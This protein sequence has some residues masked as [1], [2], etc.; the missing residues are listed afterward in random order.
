MIYSL[1]VF[2]CI[3]SL[4]IITNSAYA[5]DDEIVVFHTQ[6]GNL[7]IETFSDDAPNT[8][9]NFLKL[10]KSGFYD[11]TIFHRVIEDFMIQG[12][13]PLTKP[14]AYEQ[15]SQWGTGDAGYTI[16]AEFNN[17]K[18]NRGVVSMA[19]AT[20]P[21]S[22][23]SQFFIVHKNSN[24]LDGQYT[25]FG[26]IITNE[27]FETLDKIAILETANNDIPFDWGKGEILETKVVDRSELE[28]ILDLGEPERMSELTQQI[29]DQEYSNTALGISFKAPEGWSVQEPQ[30]ANPGIPDVIVVGPQTG[31]FPSTF[32][33][34]VMSSSGKTFDQHIDE[35][36]S[37]LQPSIEAG[38]LEILS[39]EKTTKNGKDSFSLSAVGNFPTD[40]GIL[41]V[42]F[43]EITFQEN[44]KFY[45]LTYTN[46]EQNFNSV[47]DKYNDFVESFA[48]NEIKQ[49]SNNDDNS[50]T[51]TGGCLIATATFGSELAPQV[52]QLRE[53]RDNTILNTQ[54]GTSFMLGFN[55]FYYSFS[56]SI[57]DL[58]REN[59]I[60]KE[61]VKITIT[62]LLTTLSILNYIDIDSEE[63]VLGYGIGI[64]LLNVGLYFV[65]PIII[66]HRLRKKYNV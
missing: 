40:T 37:L 7:V 28:N 50:P 23:S 27:S 51:E 1:S 20:D 36:I 54:I 19:R 63:E 49:I 42:K 47:L 8:S 32:S 39:Q 21:D 31:N 65:G 62:P 46:S 58:E 14:G 34:T 64:I 12:G 33:V 44:G 9:E 18:H 66:I 38:N 10:A 43:N 6:S 26:R 29:S 3:F 60:F 55:Q 59:P 57:A 25:V 5:Q 13:D 4:L 2:T 61:I 22:A 17:I 48:V 24:F 15:T 53:L 45:A 41:K 30:K 16:P 11:R 35:V 52:Q 56:P